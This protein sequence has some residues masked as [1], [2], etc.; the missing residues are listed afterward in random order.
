M[1]YHRGMARYVY[2]PAA[3]A[4]SP[5]GEPSESPEPAP[6]GP[7]Q[8]GLFSDPPVAA[9]PGPGRGLAPAVTGRS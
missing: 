9:A 1:L 8:P 2:L 7:E 6:P 5:A 4:G 3:E